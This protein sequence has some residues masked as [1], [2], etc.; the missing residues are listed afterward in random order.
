MSCK[1][2]F[3]SLGSYSLLNQSVELKYI[4]GAELRQ[5]LIGKQLAK[6]GYFVS[7]VAYSECGHKGKHFVDGVNVILTYSSTEAQKLSIFKKLKLLFGCLNNADSDIYIHSAGSPG[8]ISLY[9]FIRRIKFVYWVA[10]DKNV[11][12]KGVEKKTSLFIKVALYLDIKLADLII[13]QNNFQK[14]AIE[15][16][17]KKPC[18]TIK[19]PIIISDKKFKNKNR[20]NDDNIILWVGTIK[21]VKQP[22]LFLKLARALPQY[23]FKMIGGRNNRESELYD[24][25]DEKAD[26]LSNLDFL[27]F[28]HH[29]EI[30]TYYDEATILVNTSQ[31]EGF[32]NTFLEAWLNYIPVVSLNVNP[33]EV[34]ST[35]KL[36]FHSKTFNQLI[37]DVRILSN[38]CELT[39]ELGINGRKYLEKEHDI[40]NIVDS[41]QEYFLRLVA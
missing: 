18:I 39:S 4:G 29:D 36:G 7:F 33:D 35:N 15:K 38:D 24:L 6:R 12:L 26:A 27:G 28:I 41:L 23:K 21:D 17:F 11:L 31:F 22:E 9:C 40:N 10:S 30:Q 3:V 32:S 2:C 8:F 16:Q 1:I 25:I 34:I 13:T 20:S 5:V 19:N 37:E 14:D